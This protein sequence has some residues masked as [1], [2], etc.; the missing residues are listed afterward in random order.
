MSDI[1]LCTLNARY[2]HS[3]FGLRYLLANMGPLRERT[4]ML[5]FGIKDN[6]VE[7]LGRILEQRPKIV[8]MGVYIWNVEPVTRLVAEL[9]QVAPEVCVVLGGPEVSY[10]ADE[11]AVARAGAPFCRRPSLAGRGRV[12]AFA[13]PLWGW[14]AAAQGRRARLSPDFQ[15]R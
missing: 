10:D 1:V 9:K 7:L 3:S 8:G 11:L 2:W 5:E 14:Q 13:A 6:T 15:L 4:A 12:G